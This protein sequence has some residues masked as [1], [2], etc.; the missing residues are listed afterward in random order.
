[1]PQVAIP[2]IV[3]PAPVPPPV[4]RR[5][6]IRACRPSLIDLRFKGDPWVVSKER[7]AAVCLGDFSMGQ[8]T[9]SPLD[10]PSLNR[11]LLQVRF[12]QARRNYS[13][14]MRKPDEAA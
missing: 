5:I 1:M 9:V 10:V 6:T 8:V 4:T 7:Q 14:R 13:R 11:V 2:P 3:P 12:G